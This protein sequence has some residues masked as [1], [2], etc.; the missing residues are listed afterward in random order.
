EKGNYQ[1]TLPANKT[2]NLIFSHN[3]FQKKVLNLQLNAGEVRTIDVELKLNTVMLQGVEITGEKEVERGE[4]GAITVDP[5]RLQNIPTPFGDFN[6]ALISGGGLG[7]SGNNELSAS[8]S[9]RGGNFDENLVY[10]NGIEIYRPFLIRAGEQEGL[11]FVNTDMV[12]SVSFSSGG[13]QPK[14]G[15]KLSSVLNVNYKK[16]EEFKASLNLNLLGGSVHVEGASPN[17]KIRFISG[18]RHKSSRY[19][20]NTLETDGQYLPRFTDWQNFIT[21]DLSSKNKKSGTTQLSVLTSYARNR[22]E[23]L[24][25]SRVTNF[26]TFGRAFRLSVLFVGSEEM[27]YDTFQGGLKFSHSFNEKLYSE[28]YFSY[29]RARERE[30]INVEGGYQLC[31]VNSN[32]S[33]DNFNECV[34]VR[35]FGSE[36]HYGR[37]LLDATAIAV[38]NRNTFS[39]WDHT[40]IEAGFRITGE[41]IDDELYEY[42][43]LDSADFVQLDELIVSNNTL[44]ST[45]LTAYLQAKHQLGKVH[46][47]TYG[48]RM[49]YWSVNGQLVFNPRLQYAFSPFWQRDIVFTAAVGMYAQ[50][51]FY[52]ELRNFQGRV[53]RDLLAQQSIHAIVGIDWNIRLWGRPFK[54]ISEAYY[55]NLW[56]VVP[57]DIDNVRLRYYANNDA[58]AYVYGA[59]FRLS[60]EFIPGTESW[61]SLSYLQAKE[62]VPNDNR[63]FIRRPSDQRITFNLFFEDHLPNDPS[64][65]V[66][67]RAIYGSGLPYGPPNSPEFRAALS[68]GSDYVRSDIGFSKIFTPKQKEGKR[69]LESLWVGLEVLNLFGAEN[70]ISFNWVPD[71]AG[72]EFAIPNSLSQRFFNVKVI[73]KY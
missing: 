5:K 47:I 68:S 58:V 57:Y 28:V 10:V 63:G 67:L 8:Y 22:Y 73:A 70:N 48:G 56:D 46:T 35:G 30:F 18:L 52:R 54:F 21:F 43:F 60:G 64:I 13:W 23:L 7:I 62:D 55:K 50:P 29:M 9:V 11:S 33:S 69:T 25:Q 15:D 65:R 32:F 41:E 1:L 39:P 66:F 53:N 72:N 17:K 19:L 36:F 44:G 2:I 24:P 27:S 12:E 31:D 59:D 26:G 20:L 45:R 49:S 37:N 71:F 4:A 6:Q 16:P 61:I 40:K 38:E 3:E 51:P 14:Y 42:T 34:L